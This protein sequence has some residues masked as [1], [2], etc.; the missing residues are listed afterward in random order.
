MPISQAEPPLVARRKSA[1]DRRSEILRAAVELIV[2]TRALPLSMRAVGERIGASRAL[3]YA[4]FSGPDALTEAILVDHLG[5][6]QKTG[7]EAAAQSGEVAER[8]TRAA[9]LYLRHV[10]EHGSVIHVILR[11]APH[12]VTL[13]R[14]VTA[15]RN[16]ALRALAGA[17]R[18]QLQLSS[19]EAIVLVELLI[20]IPEELGRLVHGQELALD[21]ALAICQRLVRS[22]IEAMRPG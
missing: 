4:H 2:E 14:S 11:D 18:A 19:A 17:A 20:A 5:R 6:L 21:D 8:G 10:A 22:G 13:S 1:D 15:P 7:I 3:V 12:G 9:A 16:R